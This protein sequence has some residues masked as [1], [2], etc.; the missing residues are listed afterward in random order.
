MSA[1]V[2]KVEFVALMLE[3]EVV[4]LADDREDDVLLIKEAFA[5]A[6][7]TNPI[8]VAHGGEE[9]IA[10]LAGEG[11]FANRDEYPLPALLLLDL[12]MPGKDGFDVLRWIRSHPSLSGLRI[13]VLTASNR[14]PDVNLAYELG[15]NSFLVKPTNFDE[16][17][18]LSRLIKDYWLGTD[19]GPHVIPPAR[20]RNAR[21]SLGPL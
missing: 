13:L 9:A 7:I 3:S 21:V 14:T 11:K 5:R 18:T 1:S 20:R 15:A 12:K 4:L 6:Q 10:Y 8:Q 16:T 17:V 2:S 19:T